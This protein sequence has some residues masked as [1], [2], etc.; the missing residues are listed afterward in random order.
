MHRHL[1]YVR[2]TRTAELIEDVDLTRVYFKIIRNQVY[3]GQARVA[4]VKMSGSDRGLV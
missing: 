1:L 4:C 3:I 2:F